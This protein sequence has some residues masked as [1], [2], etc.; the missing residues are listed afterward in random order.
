[1]RSSFT[2]RSFRSLAVTSIAL[3]SMLGSSISADAS[4]FGPSSN[5]LVKITPQAQAAVEQA[6]KN[7]GGTINSRYQYAFNGFLIKLPDLLIPT[8]RRIP[9]IL[10]VEKDLP[11]SVGL[12][13]ENQTPTPSWGLDRSDQREALSTALGYEGR[14]GFRSAGAGATIY[15]GDSGV[16]PHTDLAGRISSV[17]YSGIADGYGATDCNGHGTHVATTAA[18]SKYGIAKKARIVSV[19]VLNCAGS[20]SFSTVIAGLDWILSPMNTNPKTQAVLNLSLGGNFSTSVNDAILKLTNSGI[21]VVAAAGNDNIDACRYSP[22]SSPTAITV[23]AT[24]ITDARAGFSNWGSCVDISAPGV[25]ITGGWIPD[26]AGTRTISGTSMAAP[27]VAGAAAI[28]LGLNPSASVAQVSEALSTQATDGVIT[29]LTGPTPNKLLYISPTDGGAAIS[30]PVVQVRSISTVSHNSAKVQVEINPGNAPTKATFEYSLD[31]T[32]ATGSNTINLTPTEIEG[33]DVIALPFSLDTLTASSTY[34]F[35]ATAINEGGP[36]TTPV[37]SFKTIAPPISAPTPIALSASLVTGYS[38]RLNG[39][40]NGNYGS[41][42]VTFLFGTDPEFLANTQNIVSKTAVVSGSKVTPVEL[43]VSFLKSETEYFYKIVAGNSV[44]SVSS[45]AIS[46]TT[47]KIIGIAPTVETFRP[48][49]GLATPLTVVTGRINPNG[50]TTSVRFVFG[51]DPTLTV[52]PRIIDIPTPFTG[53]DT[54]TVSADMAGLNP[55][56]RY[57]YRFEASNSAGITKQIPLTNTGNPVLPTIRSTSASAQTLNSMVLN[58][59]VNAGASNSRFY[60]IYGTDPLLETGTTTVNANPF[61]LTHSFTTNISANISGLLTGTPYYFRVKVTAFTGPLVD[62]GGVLLGPITRT[63]TA[64]PPRLAQTISFAL[65]TSRFYGGAPTVLNATASSGLPVTYTASPAG[66]CVIENTDGTILLKHV[67]PV[68][69][70]IGVNCQVT[71]QQGG[72]STYAPAIGQGRTIQFLRETTQLRGTWSGP[73]TESGTALDLIAVSTSQPLLNEFVGGTTPFT[74]QSRTPSSCAV[75]SVTF[76]N[77]ATAHTRAQV[78]ALW[79]GNCQIAVVFAGSEYWNA[80]TTLFTVAISGMKTPAVGAN[81]PQSITFAAPSNRSVGV[82]NPISAVTNSGL[83]VSFTVTTPAICELRTLENGSLVLISATGLSGDSNLCSVV[84]TAQGDN[85]WAAALPVTRSFNWIRQAQS[86][87]FT[88][89]SSRFYGGAPT[90]LTA[91]ATSTLPVSF[92]S[93]TPTICQVTV[94]DSRTT[95]SYVSPISAASS[96]LCSIQ[97]TQTGD[98]TFSAA[99]ALLR[100]I[101]WNKESTSLRA[102]WAGPINETGT[103]LSFTVGSSSQP[104][105]VQSLAGSNPLTITSVNPSAC[106]ILSTQYDG[107]ATSHTSAIVRGLWNTTCQIKATFAGNSYWLSSTS[108]ISTS[109]TGIR[110]PQSGA[111]AAQSIALTVPA[112]VAL[113]ASATI[114]ATATSGLPVTVTSATPLVCTVESATVTSFT[115]KGVAGLSGDLNDC[116]L[117][118]AQAG[119]DRWAPA[120]PTTRSFRFIRDSQAISFTIPTSR[121]YGGAPTVL[122]ATS[123]A[124]LP[125]QFTTGSPAI[126]QITVGDTQTT[127]SYVE[128]IASA[129]MQL[130][131]VRT[132]QPGNG[133]FLPAAVS[134]R[135]IAWMKESVRISSKLEAPLTDGE[136]NLDLLVTSASQPLLGENLGGST[137]LSVSSLTPGICQVVGSSYLGTSTAH[138]QAVIR[139]LWNGSCQLT[140]SFAGNSYWSGLT[141]T[142][143]FS[144]TGIKV[145]PVGAAAPQSITFSLSSARE[146]GSLQSLTARSTSS[147]SVSYTSLTPQSCEIESQ[148]N[149]LIVKSSATA[150]V[151]SICTIQASQA[152]DNRWAAAPS[153]NRSF[154][155]I[156]SAMV[157]RLTSIAVTKTGA[158][159]YLVTNTLLHA[160]VIRNNGSLG[161]ALPI[162]AR[163]STPTVCSVA[164]VEPFSDSRGSYSRTS[165]IGV[166]NGRCSLSI[167]FAGST[168]Q[169][170]ITSMYSITISGIK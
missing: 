32:F 83:P 24:T 5:Y 13:Q 142:V 17:G 156:R 127:L 4:L 104:S 49:G 66:T 70:S 133:E 2:R 19:R 36:F 155:W 157:M 26:L 98:A 101:T 159:P 134:S 169:A 170:Q 54:V 99:P 87:S 114:S 12:I 56:F 42:N 23:G 61:A 147:L 100:S 81:A 77:L 130:C 136:T 48:V 27:H 86:I 113:R 34:F 1:M 139:G 51:T 123:T 58:A 53:V 91:T 43:D 146:L 44:A 122:T 97:A 62:I 20:G 46:F 144:V 106:V 107:T 72:D 129:S 69:L 30:A 89:P 38:A 105:L 8:L 57:Y 3:S 168:T 31:E 64:Y 112:S 74:V 10:T 67:S 145:P 18:G 60:F 115:V 103:S 40:V 47:P 120:P 6:I 124:G 52:S 45:N 39:T 131:V 110:T 29:G 152:G 41:T 50:Q 162:T 15:I 68:S 163:T 102:Q 126:C 118:A 93:M 65:P 82:P 95:L 94:S 117:S 148:A 14:Y 108:T 71:V 80:T 158:G 143:A 164:G 167:S 161:L 22:A 150:T 137:P 166:T 119:D 21:T 73:I 55:G 153:V 96:A 154:T 16:N 111:N 76:T 28:Y 85:R 165:V 37:G 116:R 7:A 132:S 160:D 25:N 138:T 75:D 125:V 33:G 151:G 79:N 63:E 128:P 92:V 35:R 88:L 140:L 109:I 141:T 121:F 59:S 9:N 149:S 78:R 84:A 90:V 135:T 11:M